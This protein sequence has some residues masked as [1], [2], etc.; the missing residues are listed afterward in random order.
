[1]WLTNCH[2]RVSPWPVFCPPWNPVLVCRGFFFSSLSRF[3]FLSLP[4]ETDGK[5]TEKKDLQLTL[6]ASDVKPVIS[7]QKGSG[8]RRLR[9]P[10]QGRVSHVVQ[11]TLVGKKVRKWHRKSTH[12][13]AVRKRR[14]RYLG[15][16]KLL[17]HL[18]TVV[19]RPRRLPRTFE[20]NNQDGVAGNPKI[21]QQDSRKIRTRDGQWTSSGTAVNGGNR[22]DAGPTASRLPSAK[23]D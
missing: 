12:T 5:N 16:Y 3:P 2:R 14:A 1:M 21:N 8:Q 7:F 4:F 18:V 9:E 17:Y 22:G 10:Y 15:K 20:E 6:L 13:M 11:S 23:M 19:S